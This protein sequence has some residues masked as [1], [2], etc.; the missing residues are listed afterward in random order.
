M[1]AFGLTSFWPSIGKEYTI[2]PG[3]VF[4]FMVWVSLS[5]PQAASSMAGISA[6]VLNCFMACFSSELQGD[7]AAD[8]VH[9]AVCRSEE[10]T[11]E[12]Q[13]RP[14]LVCRLLLEKKKKKKRSS[15]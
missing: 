3:V 5:P 14:H 11:S 4:S 10:H 9:V 7:G 12:L 13:S 1:S 15:T 2:A 6:R 8:Y